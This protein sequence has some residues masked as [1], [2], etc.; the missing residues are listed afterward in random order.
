[1]TTMNHTLA[2]DVEIAEPLTAK[3]VIDNSYAVLRAVRAAADDIEA[4]GHL[5]PEIERL[6]R[7]A[8]FFQMG[9]PAARGGLEMTL[10]HQIEVV[11]RV[12][13]ADGS[14]G[15]N[16]GV[17][18]ATGFYAGRLA[19]EPYAELYPTRDEPTSGS[20][21]PRGRADRVEGGWMVEGQW[22][23]GSGSYS[24]QHVLGGCTA[25]EDGEPVIG[26]SGSQLLL[27]VWLPREAITVAHNWKTIGVRGSG[28]TSYSVTTPVFIP[29][30]HAFDREAPNDG[31]KDPLN[32]SVHVGHFGL[33]GVALGLAQHAVDVVADALRAKLAKG[34]K[35]DA[36][37]LQGYGEMVSEVDYTYAGVIEVARRSDEI[38]FEEGRG[39]TEAQVARMTIV[40]SGTAAM[41]RR[42]MAIATE[43][44][45]AS[46]LFDGHP[47]ERIIRDSYGVYAH[48]SGRRARFGG[49][50]EELLKGAGVGTLLV[51]DASRDQ[52]RDAAAILAQ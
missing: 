29:A 28:S 34:V 24:A 2:T 49:L 35:L 13:R 14:A 27:G 43:I 6:F 23:W 44:A 51:D 26:P 8:G 46:Y 33:T 15:W 37:T 36:A 40:Q 18:N 17:L 38:L 20:F 42:V 1:M 12:S 22:D 50:G 52:G 10:E 41:L 31:S 30:A 3:D 9:F 7:D 32:K 19:E 21:H 39:I 16:V 48:G 25:F 45:S 5:T 47:L 4:A 11:A